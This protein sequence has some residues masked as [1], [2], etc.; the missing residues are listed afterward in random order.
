[1]NKVLGS[2]SSKAKETK[3]ETLKDRDQQEVFSVSPQSK[4][5]QSLE[6]GTDLIKSPDPS[7]N[8]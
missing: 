5:T 6:V 8:G 3:K 7:S 2:I 4:H 1:M